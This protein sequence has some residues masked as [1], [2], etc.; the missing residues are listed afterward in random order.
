[1]PSEY[2]ARCS[3]CGHQGP[4][5]SWG[6]QALILDEARVVPL[7]HPRE[8]QILREHGFSF[9]RAGVRG[10]FARVD[11]RVCLDCG[12]SSE[13]ALLTFPITVLGCLIVVAVLSVL[14]FAGALA[15]APTWLLPILG[16]GSWFGLTAL[17]TRL[18][19][20]VFRA[21][22]NLLPSGSTCERCG[23]T[24]LRDIAAA[25][26]HDLPCPACSSRSFRLRHVGL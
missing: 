26:Q 18:V 3:S 11:H 1:M 14:T 20:L 10:R 17:G 7:T 5:L 23:G 12:H 25:L 4:T 6:Y 16:I 22:Q 8:A 24:Q 19:R 2:Q 9:F 15:G 13:R 21:R